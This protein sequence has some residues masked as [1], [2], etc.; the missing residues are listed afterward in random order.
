MVGLTVAAGLSS[1]L[2]VALLAA[3]ETREAKAELTAE[4]EASAS[5]FARLIEPA[6]WDVDLARSARLAD[7]FAR[8]PRIARLV[9]HES[10]TGTTQTVER[11]STTDTALRT[12]TVRRGAQPLGMVSVAFNRRYYRDQ[13]RRQVVSAAAVS[14]IA[15]VATLIGLRLLLRRQFRRPLDELSDVVRGYAT[16]SYPPFDAAIPYEE[17]AELGRVLDSMRAQIREQL[18]ALGA[19]NRELAALNHFLLIATAEVE[20]PQLVAEAARELQDLFGATQ[21]RADVD[22][23][24]GASETA[25]AYSEDGAEAAAPVSASAVPIVV[26]ARPIGAIMLAREIGRPFTAAELSL[27]S[28]VAA[29]VAS[30]ISRYRAHAAERL[31]RIAIEQLPDSVVIT[32]RERRIVYVN[33]GFTAMTGY[34]AAE[35]MG[36]DPRTLKRAGDDAAGEAAMHAIVDAGQGWL[37]RLT[38]RKKSGELYFEQAVIMPVRDVRGEITNHVAIGRDV[39]AEIRRDEQLRHAQRMDA[40][41]QLAG[42]VAHDF[43]NMLGAAL[44]QLELVELDEELTPSL[45]QAAQDMRAALERAANLTRQLLMFSRRQAMRLEAHDLNRIVAEM[46]RILTRVLGE[47]VEIA[48]ESASGPIPFQ[49]DAG[50]IEQVI[51]NLCV[52]ARDA[53]PSGGRLV[54]STASVAMDEA[55]E[56]PGA[57]AR[58]EVRDTGTG[59]SPEVQARIFEPFFTT[60]EVGQGTGLGLATTHGIVTQHGGW[61]TVESVLG[62]G[63]TIRVYLPALADLAAAGG[64][65]GLPGVVRGNA[66]VLVVEDEPLVRQSVS[67]SLRRLGHRVLEASNGHEALRIWREQGDAIDLVVTDMVMPGGISGVQL[68]ERMRATRPSVPAV[69]MSGYSLELS[70]DVLPAGFFFLAKPFSLAALSRAIDEALGR[71]D[72]R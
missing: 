64:A 8:D 7:A 13:I 55:S 66:A 1:A 61:I 5:A 11:V 35:A 56:H 71:A 2:V 23:E 67:S 68:V 47:R 39:T 3:Y 26:D 27:A 30:A 53:M 40:V 63:T 70:S 62:E 54:I 9:V 19:A 31:L 36:R 16:G 12:V 50:M 60:K 58:L 21:V 41:G 4:V 46:L 44:M 33:P 22:G 14:L 57:W 20:P 28:T 42:G 24:G 48:F 72:R 15:L 18:A 45:K 65:G 69:V 51:V 43:N 32:D 37:G 17:F 25:Y 59:M 52:N 29:Q 6:L 49:G 38:N 10:T 34:S